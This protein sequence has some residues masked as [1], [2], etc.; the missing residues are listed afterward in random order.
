MKKPPLFV[1]ICLACVISASYKVFALPGDMGFFGGISEGRRLPKTM[2]SLLSGDARIGGN[3]NQTR[4][5]LYKEIVFL[6]G[7][8]VEFTGM[9]D[10]TGAN[11]VVPNAKTGKYAQT[12]HVYPSA[13][14][15]SDAGVNRNIT[16]DVNY[17]REGAQL[18]KDYTVRDW[19]ETVT[20]NGVNY[21]LD[22]AQSGFDISIIEHETPGVGYYRGDISSRSV[23]M[24]GGGAA[25]D[26][27]ILD[28]SDSFHGYSCAWSG[29]EAHRA[30]A[31]LTGGAWQMMYQIRPGVSVNKTLWYTENE[32]EAISFEGNYKEVLKNQ[33]GLKY[34]IL[35]PPLIYPDQ[36]PEGGAS[37]PTRNTFEQLIAPDVGFLK[38]SPAME[39]IRKLFSMQILDGDPAFYLPEQFITRAQ[40]VT[41]LVKAVKLPVQLVTAAPRGRRVQPPPIVFPDV[42]PARPDYPYLMSAYRNGVAVG[43]DDGTFYSDS[44]LE[45]QEAFVMLTRALGFEKIGQGAEQDTIFTDDSQIAAWSRLGTAAAYRMGLIKPDSGG[46]IRP[47]DYVSKA[48]AAALLT[49]L[50]DY[51][52][53]GIMADYAEHI[54]NYTG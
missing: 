47:A 12:L 44:L 34:T 22:R 13:A 21:T 1:L 5:F 7:R 29:A 17:R 10:V 23:Y 33:S 2:E 16:F 42:Q 25:G 45:R 35:Q 26:R 30:E 11:G 27:L 39:D 14:S 46:G 37:I 8:P 48:E 31:S 32:P 53:V 40:F 4:S 51:M 28:V 19:A 18:I 54:V 43:R 3:P 38:G 50:I 15:G 6:S 41:A 49:A 24:S 52:R 9:L 36:P 20:V